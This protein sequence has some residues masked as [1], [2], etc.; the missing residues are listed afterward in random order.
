MLH[1]W[2]RVIKLDLIF[3][4]V[5]C[6]LV[7]IEVPEEKEGILSF[8]I[9]HISGYITFCDVEVEFTFELLCCHGIFAL[10]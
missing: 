8:V 7:N 5:K 2:L 4:F 6:C 1:Q 3:L 9:V 10:Y